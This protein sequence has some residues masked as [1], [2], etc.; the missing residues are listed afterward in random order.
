MTQEVLAQN[1]SWA[2][3]SAVPP[4]ARRPTFFVVLSDD[5]LTW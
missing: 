2:A 1:V 5:L 3:A 4:A